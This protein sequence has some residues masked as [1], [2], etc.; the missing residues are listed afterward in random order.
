VGD[1][2]ELLEDFPLKEKIEESLFEL[3]FGVS[4]GMD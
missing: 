1:A 4:V 2:G 3:S